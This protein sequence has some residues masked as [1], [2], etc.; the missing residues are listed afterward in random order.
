MIGCKQINLL[1]F[2]I[3]FPVFS[4]LYSSAK[5][6]SCVLLISQSSASLTSDGS[7]S[8]LIFALT[9][10]LAFAMNQTTQAQILTNLFHD[11]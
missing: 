8:P 2:E 5:R 3:L 11:E 10:L 1:L 7:S 6:S 4:N 9:N